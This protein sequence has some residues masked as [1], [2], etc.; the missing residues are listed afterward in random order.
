VTGVYAVN[1]D[2]YSNADR[3]GTDFGLPRSSGVYAPVQ[4]AYEPKLG[5]DLLPGHYVVGFGYD[6][7]S[8][9]SFSSALPASA[10]VA[11]SS[12]SGNTQFWALLDQMLVRNGAG[13]QDGIIALG[14][15]IHNDPENS[16]DAQQYF[17]GLLDRG[18][19]RARPE[20][21]VG[22]LFTYFGISGALGN[23]Q[24]VEAQLGLPFSNQATGVQS[25]EMIL[26]AN[27]NIHVHPGVDFRPEFQYVFRPNAQSN[28]PDA[29]VFGFKFNVE[30]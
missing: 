17:A 11:V 22:L 15:Y 12:H 10:G 18:F 27:Y 7:S 30:F 26:E 25:H 29:A 19:W 21:T 4:L 16:S 3:S 9:E 23:V 1:Q 5:K 6:S 13:H 2:L 20:D 28:I 14:G 8:F 24:A